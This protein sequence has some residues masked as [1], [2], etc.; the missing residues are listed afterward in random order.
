MHCFTYKI[1]KGFFLPQMLNL[2]SREFAKW[3]RDNS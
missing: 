2:N 1:I 3:K